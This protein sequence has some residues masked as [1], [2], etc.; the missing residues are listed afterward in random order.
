MR[1]R[2]RLARVLPVRSVRWPRPLSTAAALDLAAYRRDGFSVPSW[3]LP[4]ERLRSAQAALD[5]ILNENQQVQ[6]EQLVN[7]HLVSRGDGA[8]RGQSQFLEL[9]AMPEIADL[10]AACLGTEDVIL[11]ACQIFCK[12]AG[13]GKSVPWHQDGQVTSRVPPACRRRRRRRRLPFTPGACVRAC[14]VLAHRP[15]ARRDGMDCAR[16]IGRRVRRAAA[17]AWDARR[18]AGAV[19][20]G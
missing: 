11:W 7:A 6:P 3:R 2:P 12:P 17:G 18:R 15:A 20:A 13:M 19:A 8:V 16:P 9:A 1:A 4:I 5:T 10:A 14:A